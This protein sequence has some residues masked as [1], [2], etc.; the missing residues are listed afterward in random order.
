MRVG[1]GIQIMRVKGHGYFY[2]WRYEALDGS[3]KPVYKYIGSASDLE[4]GR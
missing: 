2:F 3:R 4:S 1:R